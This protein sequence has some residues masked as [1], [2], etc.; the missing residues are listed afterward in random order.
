MTELHGASVALV[1][2]FL[3]NT[4]IDYA[5]LER[6]VNHCIAGGLQYLTV[7]GTTAETPTLNYEE[8]IKIAYTVREITNN[9]VGLVVGAGGND[10][11]KVID[12][13]QKFD[14]SGFQGILSA[15]PSYN[16]P[17][18][19]GIYQHYA[20]IARSTTQPIVLYN[21]PAR[22]GSNISAQTTVRL[23]RD[24][25]NIVAIKEA[26]GNLEQCGEIYKNKP[27]HFALISGD[28]LATLPMCALGAVGLVS[29]VANAYPAQVAAL[30]E[31]CAQQ[32]YTN[33]RYIHHQIS[34]IT[35]AIF[36][37]GNP[38]GIKHLLYK[39]GIIQPHLRLPLV[40]INKATA[41]KI[42]ANML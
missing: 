1:T 7:L 23:A 17:S 31:H 22:T 10:T 8:Q 6:L 18:Q 26:S 13:I 28:D 11:R 4:E 38:A 25:E 40:P 19:E 39:M 42:E 37:D 41:Q 36:D 16:K 5:A 32:K 35:N 30:V 33:A 24:F 2:P 14:F 29:V 20:A 27:T 34:D 3:E 15:S 21:V 12:F 9:R